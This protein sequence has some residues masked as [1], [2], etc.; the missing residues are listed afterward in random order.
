MVYNYS[1]DILNELMNK[2]KKRILIIRCGLLGDTIDSTSVI[3]PLFDYYKEDLEI[4]WVTK[5]NLKDLFEFD[6][7][8][9][10]IF[11][12]FTKLPLLL[13]FDKLKIVIKSFFK[14]YDA[15]I[16]LE[17]GKKFISLAKYTNAKLKVGVPQTYVAEDIKNEHRVHHQLRIIESYY[18]NINRSEAFPYL[19]GSGINIFNEYK[20][21]E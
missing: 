2:K 21:E 10:P 4:E 6:E 18:K 5:S 16:N 14:P 17:L 3:R 11:V 19:K 7:K 12:K 20:I 15:V 1:C 8:I 9:N 13:N